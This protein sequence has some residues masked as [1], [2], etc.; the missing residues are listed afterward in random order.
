MRILF[1]FIPAPPCFHTRYNKHIFLVF[2]VALF[3]TWSFFDHKICFPEKGRM[4]AILSIRKIKP[5]EFFS[6]NQLFH[7]PSRGKIAI[8]CG[9]CAL[10]CMLK[11]VLYLFS[12]DSH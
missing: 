6:L 5:E 3:A 1:T 2:L 8:K 9:G 4:K 7:L 11:G 12:V 10:L